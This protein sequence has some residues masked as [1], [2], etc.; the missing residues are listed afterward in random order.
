MYKDD[1]TP[2]LKV[3]TRLS[4]E[5]EMWA[6]GLREIRREWERRD[7]EDVQAVLIL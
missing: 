2:S 3:L 7:D 1:E 4:D 5:F 6:Y